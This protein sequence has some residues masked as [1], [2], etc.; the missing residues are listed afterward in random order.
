[1]AK[2]AIDGAVGSRD[3]VLPETRVLAA[4][5]TPFLM[6][7][8]VILFLF[9]D[10]TGRLFAWP[11]APQMNALMLGAIY[12]TGVFYFIAVL[13][14]RRWQEVRFG[15]VP[16]IIGFASLLGIATILHWPN[17]THD[18]VAFWVW[19]GL[20][21]VTPFIVFLVWLRNTMYARLE[22]PQPGDLLLPPLVRGVVGLV[23]L[24]G[25]TVTV[26]LFL[27][28]DLMIAIWPWTLSPLTSRVL[29]AIFAVY[30]LFAVTAFLDPRWDSLRVLAKSQAIPPVF[31]LIAMVVSWED[32]DTT[33]PLTWV[34]AFNVVVVLVIGIPALYLF[35]EARRKRAAQPQAG[36]PV[37]EPGN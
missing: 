5:I 6:L 31:F 9:P 16:V 4:F 36:A 27:T 34:F 13:F 35:M 2:K 32:F 7:A 28:P 24:S 3:R 23:G 25:I 8:F 21:F 14:A 20:Y 29:A 11:I 22:A 33:N 19:A 10:E 15:L 18:H 37:A 17:F 26:L 30:S 1:M 12:V